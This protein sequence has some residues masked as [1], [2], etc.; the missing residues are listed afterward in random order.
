MASPAPSAPTVRLLGPVVLHVDG[1]EVSLPGATSRAL[2]AALTLAAPS[3]RSVD[4]LADDVWG[5]D[6]PQ[7]PRGAL[8]TLVSRVRAAAGPELIR[9]DAAG[10]AFTASSDLARAGELRDAALRLPGADP[11]RLA[12]VDEALALWHGDAGADLDDVPVAAALVDEATALRRTLEVI[13]AETLTAVGRAAEAAVDLA[14]LAA[15]HP[16]D[17]RLHAAWMTALAADGQTTEA[18]AVFAALRARLRDDLGASPGPEAADLNARLL[19]GEV[20]ARPARVRIGLRAA[21]NELIGRAADLA[22]VDALLARSRLVTVLGVGGLGKTR[23]AQAVAAGS[24]ASAVIVVPLAGVRNDDDVP[25]AIADA[26]GVTETSRGAR[27]SDTAPRPDLRARTVAQLADR[28]TLLVLDN[29]EQVID[30]VASWTADVLASV[31][32]LR[33]LATSR[34]P[35]AIA[36][37]AVYPL[38]PL[39]AEP[40][41]D[42]TPPDA[43]GIP[44]DGADAPVG[45][46]V[47][48][49]VER[50]RAARPDARLSLDVV[51]RLCDR[52]DGI[53]LA[54]ELAAARVRTMTPEQIEA[55]LENRFAL[56]TGGDR[57]APVR[58]RTLEAVI[59]WS[60]D[61]LDPEARRALAALS[62]LPAGF[63]AATA[64]GVLREPFADDVLD[65][66][67]SQSLL[68]VADDP[69]TGDV[70]FRMLETVR[71][72]GLARLSAS[73]PGALAEAWAAVVAWAVGFAASRVDDAFAPEVFRQIRAE[74]DNLVVVLRRALA[75]GDDPTA[76]VLFAVLCQTWVARGSLAEL[77]ALGE[78]SVEAA[79]RVDERRVPVTPLVSVLIMAAVVGAFTGDR[80]TARLVARVRVLRRRHP[81]LPPLLTA[82]ADLL[83][84][85]GRLERIP[86]A[87]E[88]L[89]TDPDPRRAVVGEAILSQYA[90]NEGDPIAG[91]AAAR[92]GWEL[93]QKHD[94]V[95]LGTMLATSAAQLASQ[96]AHPRE[97][98]QWLERAGAGAAVFGA[99]DIARQETWM[100]AGNLLG[101][102]RVDEARALFAELAGMRELTD[103]GLEMASIGWF[104]L[105]EADRVEGDTATSVAHYE[106]AMSWFG[107]GAQR[108][109]PWYLM[110]MAGFVS[111]AVFDRSLPPERTARWATRLRTRA[112]AT[113]RVRPAYVDRP[114]LGT[115]LCG[116]SAWALE[117]SDA[118]LRRRGVEALALAQVLGGR[119]DLPSLH[120][121]VHVRHAL[122]RA[123]RDAVAAAQQKASG[124]SADERVERAVAVLTERE[125]PADSP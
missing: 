7:N 88:A 115:V 64:A 125:E 96:S 21:P 100:R 38:A 19:R 124:L 108:G 4:A 17:E 73:G 27:L 62:P 84:V 106:R 23:L 53:P 18:L 86:A 95:W 25:I 65:R 107:T 70:R 83:P 33:V 104:G 94:M 47:R 66:L 11:A 101:V 99:D 15:A 80:R 22:A 55:R 112:L 29:C 75:D 120:H 56:L 31:P 26:L 89:R 10:Y 117:S 40:R 44:L 68:I 9:S 1:A 24:S 110:A 12:L 78:Q 103:D 41:D 118:A 3:P 114:V 63:S 35:L 113:R 2:V 16:Y 92:R 76:T 58:H 87:L 77:Q 116:W 85:L 51:R 123:G 60:W 32:G 72:F 91:A 105:A 36:G 67:V 48:L 57:S 79:V 6:R 102:G 74:Q 97:A 69:Q 45:D 61:L 59:E 50:A 30:G 42:D 122:L 39:A 37:E 111:A 43:A 121:D 82:I 8:Q 90:E 5:D 93:A 20:T 71:E 98:L 34:T 81:D 119:Q 49:F 46:A 109:S 54:I 52:L 28:A 13:R 14:S